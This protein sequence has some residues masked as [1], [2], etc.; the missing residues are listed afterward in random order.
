MGHWYRQSGEPCYTV[1]GKNGK[2]R[3]TTLRDA[4]TM[5]LVPSV[6]TILGVADKPALTRWMV[7]QA[8]EACIEDPWDSDW[9]DDYKPDHIKFIRNQAQEVGKKAAERGTQIHGQIEAGFKGFPNAPYE[10]VRG[11]LS[12]IVD[13]DDSVIAE[14]SFCSSHGYGG[15]IDL[16]GDGWVCDFKTKQGIEGKNPKTFAFDEMAMQLTAYAEGI[17]KPARR[18][19]VFIDRDNTDIVSVYEWDAGSY[20][21]HSQMFNHLLKYWQKKNR[22]E[23]TEIKR[24]ISGLEDLKSASRKKPMRKN[25]ASR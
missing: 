12:T 1:I 16:L 22:M 15:K 8:I 3:D 4:R 21:R 2:E 24:M 7:G 19:N 13:L 20:D 23:R 25:D 14:S 6:T 5:D 17:G 9:A 18:I 10:A 11:V